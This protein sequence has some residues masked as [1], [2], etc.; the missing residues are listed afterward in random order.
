[1]ENSSKDIVI[2]KNN[3]IFFLLFIIQPFLSLVLAIRHY[4]LSSSRNIVWIFVAFTG[5]TFVIS[6]SGIDANRQR[7]TLVAIHNSEITFS[8]LTDL[9][10]DE[11]SGYVDIAQ[12]IIIF[13]VSRVTD[14]YQ[15]LFA[16]YGLIFGYFYSR[17]I[18]YLID[19]S[20]SFIKKSSLLVIITYVLIIGFWNL[21]GFRMYTAAHIFVFG[22]MQYL[23]EKRIRGVFIAAS[24]I[25][26]HFSY[27]F[28][29]TILF[30]FIVIRTRVSILFW[31]FI[32]SFF[33]SELDLKIVRDTLIDILPP[34]FH[35][36]V[37]SYT[38]EGY[39]ESRLEMI[40]QMRWY[41]KFYERA[42]IWSITGFL[43]IFYF[44]A[45][46]YIKRIP[47]LYAL[48]GFTLLFLGMANIFSTIPSM[49]RFILVASLFAMAF[50]LLTLQNGPKSQVLR[51]YSP[52][53]GAGFTYFSIMSLRIGF[54]MIGIMALIGNPVFA[55]FYN[56]DFALIQLFK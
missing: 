20:G 28:P 24:S 38:N 11:D 37:V 25:L 9:L 48:Y 43:I 33:I 16:I 8:R 53:A 45:I 31:F 34:I 41:A 21:N 3:R 2:K 42:L 27:I 18:W 10:Y 44:K 54:D 46:Q 30:L 36:K 5:L 23:F 7:E 4:R 14:N 39:A 15:V 6:N 50:I 32:I 35:P 52:I 1:L 51:I 47:G 22:T 19:R 40:N 49:S 17:N 26:F 13:L 55:L 56:I 12:P 29:V